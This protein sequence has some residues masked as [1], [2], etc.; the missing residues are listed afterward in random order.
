MRLLQ[1]TKTFTVQNYAYYGHNFITI[2]FVFNNIYF[3]SIN[4]A[5]VKI[6]AYILV[7]FP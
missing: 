6:L 3:V 2:Y 7:F 4:I 5:D 1:E